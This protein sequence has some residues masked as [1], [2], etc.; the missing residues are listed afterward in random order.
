MN[1]INIKSILNMTKN[2]LIDY[3]RGTRMLVYAIML[4]FIYIIVIMPF[5]ECVELMQSKVSI[6]EPFIAVG[7]SQMIMITMPLL[8][9][10]TM[11]DFPRSGSETYFDMTRVSKMSWVVSQV[12]FG[13]VISVLV[14]FM[15]MGATMLMSL[16]ICEFNLEFSF[17]VVSFLSVYPDKV[18]PVASLIPSNLYYQLTAGEALLYTIVLMTM[19][20]WMI[21]LIM[22][23][24]TIT[25]K[26]IVGI[27]FSG[28]IIIA[29]SATS[30]IGSSFRWIFP[31][32]HTISWIHYDRFFSDMVFPMW[33]SYLYLGIGIVLLIVMCV[34]F[35]KKYQVGR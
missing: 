3:F 19:Y 6:F 24:F 35:R 23:F 13:L 14:T 11:A 20:M 31:M 7:N 30:I 16:D 32:A 26:K 5:M 10:V 9:I 28:V 21:S 22:L 2:Q 1:G 34:L 17:A 29:G 33:G 15:L 18:S 4:I 12:L 25:N 8:F 27:L